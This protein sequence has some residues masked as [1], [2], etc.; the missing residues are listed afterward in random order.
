MRGLDADD[1]GVRGHVGHVGHHATDQ[2]TPANRHDDRIA[3][4]THGGELRE[5]FCGD[6]SLPDDGVAGVEG[7]DDGRTGFLSVG[8]GCFVGGVEGVTGDDYLDPFTA[9]DQDA[10]AFL[11][12]GLVGD[13]DPPFDF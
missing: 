1:G 11:F 3:V 13:E 12:G 5:D 6:C 2:A 10:V 7:F 9:V 8:V 4:F